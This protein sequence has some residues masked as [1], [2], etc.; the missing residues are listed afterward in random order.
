MFNF[1]PTYF[2]GLLFG[3]NLFE[4]YLLFEL[5]RDRSDVRLI[6]YEMLQQDL[7]E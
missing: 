4:Y 3:Y 5:S 7:T 6:Q 1:D 2:Y